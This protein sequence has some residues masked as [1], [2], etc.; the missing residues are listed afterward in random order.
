MRSRERER[1]L[2]VSLCRF[3][4]A[5]PELGD[6]EL[7]QREGAQVIASPSRAASVRLG[8]SEQ[9]LRLLDD[10]REVAAMTGDREPDDREHELH[11]PAAVCSPPAPPAWVASAR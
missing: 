5:R 7:Q 6:A 1:L 11:L 3:E 8:G 2:E 10:G 9:P 4:A